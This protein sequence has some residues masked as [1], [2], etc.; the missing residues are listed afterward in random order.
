MKS[1]GSGCVAVGTVDARLDFVGLTRSFT[2]HE[3]SSTFED[4]T[5]EPNADG[6]RRHF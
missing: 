5:G 6:W 1:S 3:L 4:P 2:D